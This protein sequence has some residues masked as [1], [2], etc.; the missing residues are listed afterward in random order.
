M[1]H[2]VTHTAVVGVVKARDGPDMW[3]GCEREKRYR[4]NF[5]GETVF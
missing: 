4:R 5:D 1:G 3:L 2:F